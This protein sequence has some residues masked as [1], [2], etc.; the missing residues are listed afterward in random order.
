MCDSQTLGI[1]ALAGVPFTGGAS[2]VLLPVAGAVSGNEQREFQ[3]DL[4]RSNAELQRQQVRDQLQQEAEA[5]GQKNFDLARKALVAQGKADNSGLGD[6]SVKAIGRAIG[7]DLGQDR[8]TIEKN[9]EIANNVAAARLRGIDITLANQEAQ[10][11]DTSGLQTAIDTFTLGLGFAQTGLGIA[12]GI[13][14]LSPSPS[15]VDPEDTKVE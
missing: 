12:S 11:G 8:A 14:D 3:K 9:V 1:V 10:I 4:A 15:L 6:R 5:A 2:L 7:F 13:S